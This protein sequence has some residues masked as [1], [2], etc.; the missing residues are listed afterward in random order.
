MASLNIR[1]SLDPASQL[2]QLQ[3]TRSSL[4]P[5]N[6]LETTKRTFNTFKNQYFSTTTPYEALMTDKNEEHQSVQ[7]LQKPTK[8]PGNAY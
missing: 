7:A 6:P 4:V 8:V 1:G 3:N 5:L 2:S